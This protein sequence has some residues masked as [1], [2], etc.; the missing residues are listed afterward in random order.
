MKNSMLFMSA[1]MWVLTACSGGSQ[2]ENESASEQPAEPEKTEMSAEVTQLMEVGSTVYN[3]YC[4]ACHQ[5]N[6]QGVPSA[7][8]PLTQ[9]EWVM[10]DDTRLITTIIS[11]LQG[12]ITVK[13]ETY[14]SAMPAHGFL[15]DEQIA[16]VLTYVRHSFGNDSPAITTEAV[17]EVR[18]SL[19]K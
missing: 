12:E 5:A 3:Q 7:F 8:P 9:T 1:A 13:G 19:T 15:T 6:G 10:G 11:G 2:T 18:E 17:T 4:L 14:N 16:G